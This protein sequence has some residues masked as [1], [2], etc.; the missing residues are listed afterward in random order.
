MR[1]YFYCDKGETGSN[2]GVAKA[3][4]ETLEADAL[5]EIAQYLLI[6]AENNPTENGIGKRA[7]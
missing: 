4:T 7:D 2:I 3:L 6:F 5:R 1:V